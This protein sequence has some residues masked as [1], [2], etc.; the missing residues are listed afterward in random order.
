MTNI[1]TLVAELQAA[2]D[3][4][5]ELGHTAERDVEIK[6]ATE[7]VRAEAERIHSKGEPCK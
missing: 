1:K 4:A 5:G 3:A 7:A 6:R 2:E